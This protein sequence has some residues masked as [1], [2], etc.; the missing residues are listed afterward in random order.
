MRW[1]KPTSFSWETTDGA[2]YIEH[3]SK[4]RWWRCFR[5]G[6]R[7]GR[8]YSCALAKKLCRTHSRGG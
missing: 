3:E 2:Y 8:A 1:Q 6:K 5:K 4:G 7:I